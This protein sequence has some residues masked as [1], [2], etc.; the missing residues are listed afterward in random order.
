MALYIIP[1]IQKFISMYDGQQGGYKLEELRNHKIKLPINKYG[2]IDFNF[3]EA[4]IS[5][6]EEE[7]IS[8]LTAYLTISG[9]DNYELSSEEIKI[10]NSKTNLKEFKIEN[11]FKAKTGDVDLQ[12]KDI[13]GK[14]EYFINSG[15]ENFGIKGKTDRVA[16]IFEANT[17]T[18]DFWGFSN[19]R[20]FKY[21]MATHNHVFS[22]SGNVIKNEK[23]GLYLSACM[24][25]FTKIFSYNN[26]GTWNKIKKMTI[27]LPV[28]EQD[29]IDYNYIK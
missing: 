28:N 12:Q 20:D 26:M 4:Y 9:L 18:V 27:L 25:Y 29:E 1:F 22:L 3:M 6:L 23:V 21:K 2:N 19:Y 10:L 8:E 15:A 11:L 7:R 17:I 24:R 5:E 16:R 13:N 14:G